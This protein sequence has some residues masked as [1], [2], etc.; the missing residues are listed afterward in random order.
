M[1]SSDPS[2]DAPSALTRLERA[3]AGLTQPPRSESAPEP[4]PEPAPESAPP[5]L[6]IA[7]AVEAVERLTASRSVPDAPVD[8]AVA[9]AD[10][11]VFA[12]ALDE[13]DEIDERD[14][15]EADRDTPTYADASPVYLD[16]LD[17]FED[18]VP[19]PASSGR[20][21]A[22][23]SWD[24]ATS[25]TELP[26]FLVEDGLPAGAEP[27]AA[28]EELRHAAADKDR[29]SVARTL[30]E[31]PILLLVAAL[32]AF[33]VKTFLAQAY[34]IPSESMLPQLEVDDRVVVSKLAYD[35]HDP[36]RG[37]II[38]FDDPRNGAA[39]SDGDN[40]AGL[41]KLFRKV[42]EGIGVV[43]PSTDEFIKRVIGLPGETVSGKDGVVYIN[44]RKLVEPYLP[45]NSVTSDFPATT[46]RPGRLWVMGDN[47]SGS[48]DS[49][50]FGQIKIDTIVGRAMVTVWPPGNIS[51]L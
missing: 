23:D 11:R 34:Y 9:A 27:A 44:G 7:S 2:D 40:D 47:R 5:V 20:A 21:D 42:G 32:I 31:I 39:N 33:I 37:D 12:A 29:T 3:L 49:R 6:D 28:L 46:V 22:A 26:Y 24:R 13:E 36:R 15:P 18:V 35:A 10:A 43:Q 48:A 19:I 14:E 30:A 45:A 50:V 17:E 25:D 4:D 41:I 1:T 51:F 16:E 38:V 8:D